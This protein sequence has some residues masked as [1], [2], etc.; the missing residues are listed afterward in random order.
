M[1]GLML[2][3]TFVA[4]LAVMVKGVFMLRKATLMEGSAPCRGYCQEGQKRLE[5]RREF[6][7]W[8][9]RHYRLPGVG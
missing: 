9:A 5:V 4:S 3:M 2:R 8:F 1:R 6:A 7:G